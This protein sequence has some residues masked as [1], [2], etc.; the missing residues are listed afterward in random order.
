MNNN[1]SNPQTKRFIWGTF[2]MNNQQI[3][4]PKKEPPNNKIISSPLESLIKEHVPYPITNNILPKEKASEPVVGEFQI[5]I[6]IPTFQKRVVGVEDVIYYQIELFST[7]S[8]KKWTVYHKIN[9]FIDLNFVFNK[10]YINPPKIMNGIPKN[11]LTPS[12]ANDPEN[13]KKLISTLT[14]FLNE[15]TCRPDLIS[16]VYTINFL[17][18]E[19]H[20]PNI[21]IFKPLDLFVLKQ[22]EELKY[23]ITCSSFFKEANLLFIGMGKPPDNVV[24]SIFSKVGNFFKSPAA[25]ANI[26][27][28]KFAIY[29]IIKNHGGEHMFILLH[30]QDLTAEVTFIHFFKEKNALCVGMQ[31]GH[32]NLFRV[33]I[34]ESSSETRDFIEYAGIIKAHSSPSLGCAINFDIGYVYSF[35]RENNIKISE[36]N[37]QSL[38]KTIPITQQKISAVNVELSLERIIVCDEGGSIYIIDALTEPLIPKT[39][40]IIHNQLLKVSC[41]KVFQNFDFLCVG[42]VNGILSIYTMRDIEIKKC[43]DINL[44]SKVEINDVIIN[45]KKEIY[46]A[47][48]NGSIAV[49]IHETQYPEYILDFHLRKVSSLEWDEDKKAI[50]SCSEDKSIKM[51]QVPISW[52][53]EMLR[54]SKG[55]N[56]KNIVNDILENNTFGSFGSKSYDNRHSFYT[57]GEYVVIQDNDEMTEKKK[58]SEDLDG[59]SIEGIK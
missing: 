29:N 16:S 11:M 17:K 54:R 33:Y 19:N 14:Q 37:Y 24:S 15:I 39:V 59:W 40:Q 49:Y 57:N 51:S 8:D 32:I 48:N 4:E 18:L 52:S 27:N 9:D 20:Y 53:P 55:I 38:M 35:S 36:L 26:K 7:I 2:P 46:I 13:H 10:F 45:Q 47:M 12:I 42:N 50:I 3:Q 30:S 1:D 41:L 21:T 25:V 28:G 56:N 5:T 31:N 6:S 34:N 44:Y 23:P 43:K 22:E 58:Y